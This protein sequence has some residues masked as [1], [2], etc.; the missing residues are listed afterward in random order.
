MNP[1]SKYNIFMEIFQIKM[2]TVI[3]EFRRQGLAVFM[4]EKS[5]EMAHDQGY[6]VIRMDCIN[7]FE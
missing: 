4:A 2:I 1:R 5:K 6:N 3:P 7:P